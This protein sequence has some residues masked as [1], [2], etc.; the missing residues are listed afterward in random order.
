MRVKDDMFE[1][2]THSLC[3]SSSCQIECIAVAKLNISMYLKE[4]S[5]VFFKKAN[6]RNK[7]QWWLS[8]F[9]SF[10]L[11]SVVRKLLWGIECPP[12]HG[13]WRA[14]QEYLQDPIKLFI[15][16][17]GNYDPLKVDWGRDNVRKNE[18]IEEEQDQNDYK[19]AQVAVGWS[20]WETDG[21]S[22]STEYLISLFAK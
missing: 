22:G 3:N 2:L 9:Y 16:S 12:C 6:M 13:G 20:K 10:C 19:E 15:A 5:R 21:I 17:S 7:R 18:Y 1:T 8:T 14:C 11:Q 4:L